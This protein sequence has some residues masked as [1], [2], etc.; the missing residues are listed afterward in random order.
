MLWIQQF[1][2]P[3][4]FFQFFAS[5]LEQKGSDEEGFDGFMPQDILIELSRGKRLVCIIHF[6]WN[7]GQ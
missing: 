1:V 5:G 7:E 2:Y 6:L 4:I 3:S